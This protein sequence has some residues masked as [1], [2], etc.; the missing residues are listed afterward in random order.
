MGITQML[1]SQGA[2]PHG[3][4]GWVTA[5]VMP[6]L[7]DKYCGDLAGLLDLRAEDDVLDVACG[8]GL[9][10]R[11]YARRVHRM[12]GIDQSEIQIRLAHK[13]NRDLE[14][15]GVVEIVHGD[16]T[17]L[18]W[19]DETFSAVTC[20]CV[21]CFSQPEQ[22]LREMHRVLRPGGRAAFSIDYCPDEETARREA[23]KWGLPYWTEA[24]FRKVVETAGFTG[25]GVSRCGHQ[26]FVGA[27]KQQSRPAK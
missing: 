26:A 22:A 12:T 24:G 23:G 17:A 25:L 11:R 13:R 7:T 27:G 21:G 1:A 14:T 10:L 5:W 8:S 19:P 2:N 3:P 6:L 9:F 18:P 4:L 20:N 16:A 15:A